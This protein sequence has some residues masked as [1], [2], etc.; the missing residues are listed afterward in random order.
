[1]SEHEPLDQTSH[2]AVQAARK[3]QHAVE[4]AR[5]TQM[6]RASMD[7]EARMGEIFREQLVDVLSRGT[8]KDRALILARVPYICAEITGINHNLE[9][10][11]EKLVYAPL[12]QK[13]VFGMVTIILTAVVG[14]LVA[15][16]VIE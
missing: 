11:K 13:L 15:L 9:I 2:D 10:I 14:A 16:V 12:I 5:Q 3:L 1:M 6:E 7:S 8:E 4:L